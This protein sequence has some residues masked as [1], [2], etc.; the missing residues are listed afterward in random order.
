MLQRLESFTNL[1][2]FTKVSRC[3]YKLKKIDS[4]SVFQKLRFGAKS[5]RN[6]GQPRREEENEDGTKHPCSSVCSG[7]LVQP[8]RGSESLQR[9]VE[10]ECELGRGCSFRQAIKRGRY[11]SKGM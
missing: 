10:G 6:A 2:A 4:N 9:G 5:L 1:Y 11:A 8:V 3:K 7:G